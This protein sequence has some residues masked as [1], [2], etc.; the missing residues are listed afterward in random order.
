MVM[1]HGDKPPATAVE[2]SAVGVA[3]SE[4]PLLR[5]EIG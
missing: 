5:K 1:I 4:Q 3:L 2:K